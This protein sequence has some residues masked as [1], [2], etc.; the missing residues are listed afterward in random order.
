MANKINRIHCS[1]HKCLTG[2]F[3]RVVGGLY[4]K[5]LPWSAGYKHFDSDI[6][7]FN[8]HIGKYKVMSVNNHMVNLNALGDYRIS[9]FVRDPRDMIV[10]GYFYHRRGAEDWCNVVAPR[11]V[12][13]K[14]CNEKILAAMGSEHSFATYLQSLPEEEGLLTEIEFRRPHFESMMKWP[15]DDPKIKLFR[16]EEI[17][18]SEVRVFEEVFDFYEVPFVEKRIGIYLA[19]RYSAKKQKGKIKHIRN[20]EAEQWKKHFTPAVTDR[21]NQLFPGLLDKLGYSSKNNGG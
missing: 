6:E 3:V 7:A 14:V 8:R 20:P 2:Y 21:F 4:N 1:Y 12:E 10:S 18:G 17:L 9:R 13:D 5:I 15:T 11:G 19:D 16:Y